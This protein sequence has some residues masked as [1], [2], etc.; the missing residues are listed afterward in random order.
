[1]W[2]RAWGPQE[3]PEEQVPLGPPISQALPW[4]SPGWDS[5]LEEVGESG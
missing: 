1:M 3:P 5:E 2:W 4:S